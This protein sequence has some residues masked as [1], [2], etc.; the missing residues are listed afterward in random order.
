M[1]CTVV[2]SVERMVY[3]VKEY[4]CPKHIKTWKNWLNCVE[5]FHKLF[6]SKELLSGFDSNFIDVR[7]NG[8]G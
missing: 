5:E 8:N 6:F 1:L 7:S 4:F 3:I 2:L